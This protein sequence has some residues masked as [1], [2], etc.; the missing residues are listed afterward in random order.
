MY[1]LLSTTDLL[2]AILGIIMVITFF[3][4][5]SRLK[6]IMD[7]I[8]GL[9]ELE[10]RKPENRKSIKCEKCRKDFD[11]SIAKKDGVINCPHCKNIV[12]I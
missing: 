9:A 7:A 6:R 10:F 11:I 1:D 8:E 5:A 4:M 3:I 12:K 2:T